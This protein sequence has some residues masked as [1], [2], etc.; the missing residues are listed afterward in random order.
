MNGQLV[1]SSASVD[2]VLV[3]LAISANFEVSRVHTFAIVARMP[4]D[5][6]LRD[7]SNVEQIASPMGC[8]NLPLDVEA[9][10]AITVKA[11]G[12]F[13]A[14]VW[15]LLVDLIPEPIHQ[16]HLEMTRLEP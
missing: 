4:Y 16:Q 14:L 7:W 3:V 6:P 9:A 13:P 11:I 1:V 8:M 10:I 2:Y 12:P 15:S 5:L